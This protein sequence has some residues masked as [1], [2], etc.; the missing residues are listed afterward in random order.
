MPGAGSPVGHSAPRLPKK[1]VGPYPT[2]FRGPYRGE[3][4]AGAAKRV[5]SPATCDAATTGHRVA[6]GSPDGGPAAGGPVQ[7]MV[8]AWSR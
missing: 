1:P 7:A 5:D 4:T 2:R 6:G 8:T 3:S